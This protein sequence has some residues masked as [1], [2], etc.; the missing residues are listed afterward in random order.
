[1]GRF[2]L[3]IA[4]FV[5]VTAA[6]STTADRAV[7]E[8]TE[9]VTATVM[10]PTAATLET[11]STVVTTTTSSCSASPDVELAFRGEWMN[12]GEP[13]GNVRAFPWGGFGPPWIFVVDDTAERGSRWYLR[14]DPADPRMGPSDG[15]VNDA[16]M[17]AFARGVAVPQTAVFTG[18]STDWVELWMVPGDPDAV[19]VVPRT[20]TLFTEVEKWPAMPFPGFC[21]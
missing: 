1:M 8:T 18:F 2:H 14:A 16:A 15:G 4:A 21:E 13:T 12:G 20:D 5:L 9:D 7:V 3:T 10:P 11:L 19:Y 6:C 17:A